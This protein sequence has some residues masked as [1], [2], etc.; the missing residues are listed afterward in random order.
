VD[1]VRNDLGR[2]CAPGTVEAPE[3]MVVEA[4]PTVHQLVSTVRGRLPSG[5]P[6]LEAVRALFPGG[7]MTGAPKLRAM[8]IIDALEE[9]PRGVYSGGLGWLS[10][11]GA[12]D[13]AMTIRTLVLTDEEA[14]FGVGGAVV[15][16]SDAAAEYD[17]AL[18]KATAL[19]GAIERARG[20]PVT[21]D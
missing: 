2:V 12:L 6:A 10:A 8:E 20:G 5:T 9:R 14:S 19:L 18:A 4:H 7:S 1:L 21:I 11:G 3:M 16:L 13:L 17:E 15:A